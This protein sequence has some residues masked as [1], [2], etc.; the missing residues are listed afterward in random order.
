MS[1]IDFSLESEDL[2]LLL[3]VVKLRMVEI[4]EH[5]EIG[6]SRTH[7]DRLQKI[8]DSIEDKL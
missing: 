7:F 2:E 3:S 8:K 4:S 5:L 6:E 1:R